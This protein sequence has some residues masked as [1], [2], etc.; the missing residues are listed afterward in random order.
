MTDKNPTPKNTTP[1]VAWR[2]NDW[3]VS[4]S[5][6]RSTTYLLIAEG[7]IRTVKFGKG[8]LILTSPAEFVASLGD[9]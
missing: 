7:R 6:P 5:I 4:T 1:Q 3:C 2:V 8:R 9:Q